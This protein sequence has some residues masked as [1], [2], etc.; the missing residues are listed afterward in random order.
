MIWYLLPIFTGGK[1]FM[2]ED[3][4][5]VKQVCLSNC[6]IDYSDEY[7][8]IVD[9][10]ANPVISM[11]NED[12]SEMFSIQLKG[13]NE[14]TP[15][16]IHIDNLFHIVFNVKYL[17]D[18]IPGLRSSA[19]PQTSSTNGL[20]L[21]I[22]FFGQLVK[23]L[24]V[25]F[26]E[27]DSLVL[28]YFFYDRHYFIV[29]NSCK[30]NK[31]CVIGLEGEKE[32]CFEGT[33]NDLLI[34]QSTKQ[35]IFFILINETQSQIIK[36]ESLELVYKTNQKILDIS[37]KDHFFVFF[38][39][40]ISKIDL[41]G[42][43]LKSFSLPSS[44]NQSLEFTS[45]TLYLVFS[46]SSPFL[47]FN[48]S[49]KSTLL[50]N[51]NID[52][53]LTSFRSFQPPCLSLLPKS[54]FSS[55]L[56][57]NNSHILKS[58]SPFS[59]SQ[60]FNCEVPKQNILGE[61]EC[62]ECETGFSLI[63]NECFKDFSCPENSVKDLFSL[64]CV[65]CF[66]GCSRCSGP[67][68]NQCFACE[69]EYFFYLNAC[70]LTCPPGLYGNEGKCQECPQKCL[71]C[72]ERQC[73]SCKE[74]FLMNGTCVEKCP[75]DFLVING[76][77]KSCEVEKCQSC[78]QGFCNTC[79]IGYFLNNLQCKPCTFGC[80]NCE[81]DKRCLECE[82]SFQIVGSTCLSCQS[83]TKNCSECK[84]FICSKCQEGFFLSQNLCLPCEDG[85]QV[86]EES[87]CVKC[88]S[89]FLMKNMSC[90]ECSEKKCTS[91]T[92]HCQKCQDSLCLSCENNF[93]LLNGS[94]RPCPDNCS[95][96]FNLSCVKCE[97]GVILDGACTQECPPGRYLNSGKCLKCQENCQ[98]CSDSSCFECKVDY[99]GHFRYLLIENSCENFECFAGYQLESGT[100][101]RK[102][103]PLTSFLKSMIS[104]S[105]Q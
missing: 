30:S 31:L 46:T 55:F 72:S 84:D 75:E 87:R 40:K 99:S 66:A 26:C 23:S 63:A 54:P 1:V 29:R 88:S 36:A 105:Y 5:Y 56:F 65:K 103:S 44:S 6:L 62:L 37:I 64:T 15:V 19:Y 51:F 48:Q 70:L 34:K 10:Q 9:K 104:L 11:K 12:L 78:L 38:S 24:W 101:V 53:S 80:K 50:L 22:D 76:E 79:K 7:F 35:E 39:L 20:V 3:F 61:V 73:F 89:G 52:L 59:V 21:F 14:Y 86:C 49:S 2:N 17:G 28:R 82:E 93:E 90:V 85:C 41:S 58:V 96:C 71:T 57:K 81:S 97:S 74:S 83:F 67:E 32:V 69:F 8:F 91:C 4:T 92:S 43:E 47:S 95:E 60:I 45:E 25:D 33:W 102:S 77:C 18:P 16:Q 27:K 42:I 13:K 68:E 100:C 98:N 94:C